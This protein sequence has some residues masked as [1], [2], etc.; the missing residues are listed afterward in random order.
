MN[1]RVAKFIPCRDSK[2]FGKHCFNR[3]C[4]FSQTAVLFNQTMYVGCVYDNVDD[5]FSHKFSFMCYHQICN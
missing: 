3:T 5:G 2:K 4:Q 1:Y